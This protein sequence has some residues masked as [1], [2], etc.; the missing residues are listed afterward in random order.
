[1][2]KNPEKLSGPV[3]ENVFESTVKNMHDATCRRL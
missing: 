3:F 1:M 2:W